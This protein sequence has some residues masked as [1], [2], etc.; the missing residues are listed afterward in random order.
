MRYRIKREH[1]AATLDSYDLKKFVA[2]LATSS[3]PGGFSLVTCRKMTAADVTDAFEM[4]RVFLNEDEHYLA[5]SKAYGD[6]GFQ[7]LNDALDLFLEQPELGFVWMAYDESGAAGVCVICYGISTSMGAVVA[8][9]DDVSVKA[10]RRG[11]GIGT[12]LLEQLKDQLRK[13][14]VTRIDVGVHLE[15]PEARRFYE[16][17]GFVALNEERLAC[18]I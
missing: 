5:S 11:Q 4:L 16:A 15:N 9:L 12:A 14:S 3:K 10:E 18:V 17:L 7:G 13:E 2:S 6:R 8:K 1:Y